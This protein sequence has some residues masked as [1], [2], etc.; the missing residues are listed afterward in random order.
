MSRIARLCTASAAIALPATL[1]AGP[2]A[3]ATGTGSAPVGYLDV[4]Q[5]TA[6]GVSFAGWTADPDSPATVTVT[7]TV[8]GAVSVRL[9]ANRARADVARAF[10]AFGGNRGFV[11]TAVVK[12]GTH[13]VCWKALNL[14]GGVDTV[15]GCRVL[16]VGKIT[17]PPAKPVPKPPPP[18]KPPFGYLDAAGYSD[19]SVRV[20]GW[21]IDPDTVTPTGV[22]VT[23]NGAV[24]GSAVASLARP[25]VAK[26]YPTFG[27]GHG[28]NAVVAHALGPGNYQLCAVGRNT[29][30]GPSTQLG[31]RIVAVLPTTE[32]AELGTSTAAAAA[33]DL[34]AQAIASHAAKTSD[35]PANASSAARIAIAARALL[36]QATGRRAAPVIQAG[37]PKFVPS[38]P[39][40]V[41]DVQSVMGRA[42][43]LGTYPAAR[44][45]GRKGANRSLELFG[46]D[47]L[48]LSGASG[49]GIV[50]AAAVLPANG[51]TVRPALPGYPAGYSKLRAEVAVDNALAQ[52][53][54]PYV[55]AAAGAD[56]FDCSGLTQWAWGKA[57]VNLYHYTGSQAVEGVRVMPN[58]L[59]PG[60]LVLFGADLHHVGMYLGAGYMIDAPYTGSYVRINKI[61][62]YGDFTL[63]VRP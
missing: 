7:V 29:A 31:C 21:S 13:T 60:D 1:L 14:G 4:V 56:T 35:F 53:G 43:S 39:T 42:P 36:Q 52:L 45:G 6:T 17:T 49:D 33:N 9:F 58:Q 50:G 32:P 61:A 19:K 38:G 28:F 24:I 18:T 40:T 15:L 59:L 30:A 16:I 22:D 34:Q 10:P 44:T 47:S 12:T 46:N 41:A 62:W 25:D 37:I 11:G 2:A 23:V 63:A 3:Y 8:D 54:K 51:R 26:V 20:A 55:W 48:S 57:G 5:A 27:V